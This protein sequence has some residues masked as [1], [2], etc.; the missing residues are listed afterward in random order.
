MPKIRN[1]PNCDR[2]QGLLPLANRTNG[3]PINENLNRTIGNLTRGNIAPNLT[4]GKQLNENIAD[5]NVGS[6]TRG[7]ATKGARKA[8]RRPAVRPIRKAIKPRKCTCQRKR[9]K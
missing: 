4:R 8:I 5:E 3:Q 7:K 6:L 1:F 2:S 9:H